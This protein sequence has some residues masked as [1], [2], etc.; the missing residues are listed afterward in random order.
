MVRQSSLQRQDL[1]L[2]SAVPMLVQGEN[3]LAQVPLGIYVVD[4]DFHVCDMNP[5][6]RA[7]LGDVPD[8]PEHDFDDLIHMLWPKAYA[9]DLI[10][11][12]RLT[13]ETGEPY[14]GLE[15]TAPRRD[16]ET[17]E[18]HE[19]RIH[20]ICLPDGRYGV[21]CYLLDISA[22]VQLREQLLAADR[23]KDEFLAMLAHELR[24]PL[25]PIQNASELLLRIRASDP[26][27]QGIAATVKRQVAH[28]VRL[29][30][31]LL[32]V[33]RVTRGRIELRCEPLVLTDVVNRAVEMTAPLIRDKKHSLVQVASPT[34]A[35]VRGDVVR[36]TQAVGNILANSV[37]YT[38]AGGEICIVVR[39]HADCA[40]IE[41]SDNG[42]GISPDLLPRI[43]EPFVQD[44]RTLDRSHGGLGIGLCVARRLIEMH[45]GT[46][47]ATSPGIGRGSTFQIRLPLCEPSVQQ[48][49]RP[50]SSP[51]RSRRVLVVD[52]DA[53]SANVLVML[54]K[55]AGHAAEAA[56]FGRDALER[57]VRFAPE[58]AFVDIGLP[59]ING[60]ELARQLRAL[61]GNVRLIALTGHGLRK[62]IECARAAGFDAHLVKPVDLSE[63][64][65]EL[66]RAR[67]LI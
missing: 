26:E 33:S 36:L 14:L 43:F 45:G 58:A 46:L 13:L 40:G 8:L 31:D 51:V 64:E 47:T 25:A 28:M 12:F 29:V 9:D 24:T 59:D 19:W 39:A 15:Q 32:D 17:P 63:L 10:R 35:T 65:R 48:R 57:V 49:L 27:I 41:I 53:D 21:V 34:D 61:D 18:H 3:L 38:D 5:A 62:D 30:D 44:D 42:A 67:S 23:Q 52:D 54:L 55:E 60:Y 2:K 37:K 56:Y 50:Q 7:L 6:A 11:H 20:R 22:H 4:A 1:D 16:R 66:A